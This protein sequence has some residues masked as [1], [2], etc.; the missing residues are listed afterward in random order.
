[1][2][3]WT[4]WWLRCKDEVTRNFR[5]ALLALGVAV[6]LMLLIA[7][8]NVANLQLARLVRRDEEF[9]IRTAL[10]ASSPRLARQLLTEALLIARAWRRGRAG[11]GGARDSRARQ[12]AS[13]TASQARRDTPRPGGARGHRR[14]RPRADDRRRSG[15]SSWAARR[16]TLPTGLRS[17]RRLTGTRHSAIRAGL[18]VTE[19][20]FALMLLVGAGLLARSV[21]RLL[22]VDKGFDANNLLTLEINSVGPRYDYRRVGVRLPRPRARCRA[23][24][25]RRR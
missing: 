15:S 4:H 2:R 7:I 20:A 24:A 16:R 21:V 10:G 18:V 19:L 3:R 23:R 9:A 14:D 22:D 13:A 25:A 6:A 5:P 1:M 12:A 8:A 17:G 11:R